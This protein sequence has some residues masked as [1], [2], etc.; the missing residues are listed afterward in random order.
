MKTFK[1]FSLLAASL[2]FF[3]SNSYAQVEPHISIQGT[4]KD[5]NGSALEDGLTNITFKLYDQLEGGAAVWEE[6]AEVEVFGGVYSHNLGSVNTFDDQSIFGSTLFLGIT[7]QGGNELAPRTE[8]TY[9][10][11]AISVASTQR[12]A[13][14]GCSGQVGDIKYSILKPE[15]FAKENGDCW[16]PMDGREIAVGNK[17]RDEY[18]WRHAVDMSG[19]F[20]RAIEYD[21]EENDDPG[22]TSSTQPGTYQADSNK[23]HSHSFSG[24]TGNSGSHSHRYQDRYDSDNITSGDGSYD[25]DDTGADEEE[26]GDEVASRRWRYRT[27]DSAG[28]HSHSFSGT[29]DD[30]GSE[31]RPKNKNFY[32][33]IRIN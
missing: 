13:S 12:I 3:V 16:V 7:V 18:G 21:D 1:I 11:Y 31:S 15:D 22:R 27:T 10:P 5:G 6:Q 8:L 33:Y 30:Q 29:T 24:T 9:A 26:G 4:L 23:S 14:G 32:I 28:E 2:L 20:I 19:M 25:D 17:L